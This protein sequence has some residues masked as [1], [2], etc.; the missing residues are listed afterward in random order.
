ML[1]GGVF[2]FGAVGQS[3]TKRIQNEYKNDFQIKAV[4]DLDPQKHDLAKNVFKLNAYDSLEKMLQENLDFVLITST[5]HA[6]ADAAV[7]CAN[8]KIPFLIEKP[9]AL[10]F[11][12]G[13][14]IC[15]AVSK[16][17]VKTVI[18]YSMRYSPMSKKI[19]MMIDAGAIGDLLSVCVSSYRGFGFYGSG[20]RHPA[21]TNPQT[22]GGW[23][24]HHMTHIIDYAIWLAG[25]VEEVYAHALTT[26]PHDLKS[27]ELI[28]TL[29]KFKNGVIGTASDQIGCLRDHQ[30]QVVGTNGGLAEKNV[31]G[32][33]FIKYSLESRNYLNFELIDPALDYQEEDGLSHFFK[34][35]KNQLESQ[36]PVSGGLYVTRI[37]EAIKRSAQERRPIYPDTLII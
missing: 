34:V 23:I 28:C 21:I 4:V 25:E 17:N 13:K 7:L 1:K 19:K 24:I 22:S 3:M 31:N 29:I 8:S 20:K 27:E 12:D 15:D 10:N 36:M 9:I 11:T 30:L 14:R 33:S 32:K 37:C 35:I 6:H 2:G 18:N 16:N 26:A 5:N